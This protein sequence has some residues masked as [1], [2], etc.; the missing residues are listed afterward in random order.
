MAA[1]DLSG[2]RL[3]LVLLLASQTGCGARTG[4]AE[5]RSASEAGAS[6]DAGL[7]AP[8]RRDAS[9][10]ATDPS[11]TRVADA[12]ALRDAFE[13]DAVFVDAGDPCEIGPE[14]L[15]EPVCTR[16]LFGLP[17]VLSCPGGFVD[18]VAQG[19][20]TLAWECS[21]TRAE[22]RFADRIYRG[23]RAADI[24]SLCIRTEFD[25]VD[26]CHWQSSQRLEGDA[27][28]SS[29]DLTY[30]EVAI[31]GTSCFPPCTADSQVELR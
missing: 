1:R 8:T 18:V 10:D 4:L 5:P 11:D 3:V 19:E 6:R 27:S 22:A 21:G 28:R 29:L 30:R 15:R 24:V 25:Y 7:D 23:Q 20:G 13:P 9:L 17:P 2:P 31:S 16:P 12:L 14:P 26:G